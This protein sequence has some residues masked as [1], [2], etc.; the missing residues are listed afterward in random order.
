MLANEILRITHISK[1]YRMDGVE[2]RALSD[3]SLTIR[4]GEFVA[5]MGPSGSGKST[6]MHIIGCLDKPT[7]GSVFIEEHKISMASEKELAA[8]R[9]THI[10]FVF[11]QFNLLRRTTALANVELPLVY[12]KVQAKER[13]QRA[14]DMLT[15]VALADKLQNFPSQLSGGQQQRVAMARALVTNPTIVLADEPTGNLDSKSGAEILNLLEKLNKNGRTIVV[16]THDEHVA[17]HAKRIIRIADGMI[18]SDKKS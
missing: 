11:Q 8:I 12:A 6:L 3:V 14:K 16:V 17:S 5:I 1:E 18:L 2:F 7:E 13:K 15:E 4:K 9:N 10:G